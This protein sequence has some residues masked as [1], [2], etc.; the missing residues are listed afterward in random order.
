MFIWC[1]RLSELQVVND[2]NLFT[3]YLNKTFEKCFKCSQPI[4]GLPEWYIA[5]NVTCHCN[6]NCI[7]AR[8]TI[9]W[10]TVNFAWN[11]YESVLSHKFNWKS[12]VSTAHVVITWNKNWIAAN[13]IISEKIYMPVLYTEHMAIAKI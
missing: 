11:L 9:R 12:L 1:T 2:L 13:A 5:V 10:A 4:I 3:A 6:L 8:I 7:D